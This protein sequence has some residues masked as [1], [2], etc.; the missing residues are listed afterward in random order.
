MKKIVPVWLCIAVML[1]ATACTKNE[2]P[3]E[4]SDVAVSSESIDAGTE[5]LP[6]VTE[7]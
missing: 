6:D 2:L 1:S 4:T 7:L 5:L 3:T